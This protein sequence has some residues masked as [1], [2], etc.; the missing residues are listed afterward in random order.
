MR[1]LFIISLLLI[2]SGYGYSQSISKSWYSKNDVQCF[3]FDSVKQCL[4][5]TYYYDT[6]EC[7][8]LKYKV[9]DSILTIYN[10]SNQRLLWWEKEKT[11]FRIDKLTSDELFLT[12]VKTEDAAMQE[13]LGLYEFETHQFKFT[14]CQNGC[15][16]IMRADVEKR[17]AK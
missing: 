13:Y 16:E 12:L 1:K 4:V 2:V 5:M 14:F 11:V 6:E 9:K 3:T 8:R 15:D 10:Y 7:D 17:K